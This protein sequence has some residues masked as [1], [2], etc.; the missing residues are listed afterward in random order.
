MTQSFNLSQLA[1]NLNTSGQ[2]DATDGLVNAVPVAN[3]GTGASTSSAAR[4]NLGLGTVSTQNSN[5][6]SITGGSITGV[7]I[8]GIT[9]LAVADGGTGASTASGA[10]TNLGLGSLAVL[11]TVATGNIDNAAVTPAKLAQPF[12]A[13]SQVTFSGSA[14]TI[15]TSIPTWVK[16]ITIDFYASGTSAA[17]LYFQLGAPTASNTDYYGT[18]HRLAPTSV[19]GV[20]YSGTGFQ[21]QLVDSSTWFGSLVITK[22]PN[23]RWVAI[24]QSARDTAAY[25][26]LTTGYKDITNPTAVYA[27]L[28]TGTF[29]DGYASILYE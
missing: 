7:S 18:Y 1:N 11:N 29:D 28:S 3:G 4:T 19:G 23:N 24:G 12:T 5:S 21:F 22:M 2:L 27:E 17:F 9:D 13:T 20:A 15:S 14:T 10:R 6:V 25:T 16:R 26:V 8:S